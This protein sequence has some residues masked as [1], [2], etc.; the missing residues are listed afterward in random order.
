MSLQ[1]I[2]LAF[3]VDGEV[4]SW[5]LFWGGEGEEELNNYISE[6]YGQLG[7]GVYGKDAVSATIYNLT[8]MR[9]CFVL[10]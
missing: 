5:D 2:V 9:S 7:F 1:Y 8:E 10:E 4:V 3:D 6:V